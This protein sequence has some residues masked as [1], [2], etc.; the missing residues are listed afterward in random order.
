M[1]LELNINNFALLKQSII[2]FK[3]GLNVLSGET[4]AGKSIIF[5]ALSVCLGE[6]ASK[7]MI[8]SGQDHSII[9]ATFLVNE[10]VKEKLIELGLYND[11]ET[12]IIRRD[13]FLEYPSIS[14]INGFSVTLNNLKDI[15]SIVCDIYG[16]YEHQLLLDQ[17]N[18][19]PLLDSFDSEIKLL[20]ENVNVKY[21]NYNR[22]SSEL[23]KLK[24]QSENINQEI[25]YIE[26]QINEINSMNLRPGEDEELKEKL[27]QLENFQTIYNS[28][29]RAKLALNGDTESMN[30][31]AISN[32][33]DTIASLNQSSDYDKSLLDL[34]KR[35]E[36]SLYEIEDIS[37]N[38][39]AYLNIE[40]DESE[41]E[42]INFRLSNIQSIKKKYNKSIDEVISYLDELNKNLCD[43]KNIETNIINKE[44]E[45]ENSRI[46]YYRAAEDLSDLRKM[47]AVEFEDK[48]KVELKELEL[49]N[50]DFKVQFENKNASETGIDSI[51]FVAITNKGASFKPIKEIISGGEMSRFMLAIKKIFADDDFCK[52]LVFDEVD[53]GL[54]GKAANSV[55]NRLLELSKKRQVILISHLPQIISKA[56]IHFKITKFDDKNETISVIKEL[57][58][59]ERIREIARL[60]SGDKIS[61]SMLKN[62][63]E[64]LNEREE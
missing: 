1:L 25:D 58:R 36:S 24:K 43:L 48:L 23:N 54:S 34:I 44:N 60:L 38:L 40:F 57:N 56:D 32:I 5:E 16:Q 45:L 27:K 39:D 42:D 12:F 6:R 30:Q 35:L 50:I 10:P 18:Y 59:E 22:L 8:K 14:R 2:R 49:E 28:I 20:Y 63:E 37:S 15:A 64:L 19:L 61:D 53:A 21:N 4:G 3:N 41:I 31:G 33:N 52:T 9:E 26:F 29:M 62:A 51:D 13:I 17:S 11:E 7:S 55:G 47:A 46:D